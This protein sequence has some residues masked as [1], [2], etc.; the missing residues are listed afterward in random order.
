MTTDSKM[1]KVAWV[2]H[3]PTPYKAPF[4]EALAACRELDVTC[5]FL[6]WDDPQ[7]AWHQE[8]MQGLKY[9]VLPGVSVRS[10]LQERE[11]IHCGPGVVNELRRG[12]FDLVVICGY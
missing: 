10:S 6:Y 8:A 4:F 11:Y 5:F 9:K 7:R 2:V 12:Q 1:P 3:S